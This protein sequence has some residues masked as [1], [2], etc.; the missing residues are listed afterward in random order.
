LAADDETPPTNWVLGSSYFDCGSGLKS[1]FA[2][3]GALSTSASF[4]DQG[5]ALTPKGNAMKMNSKTFMLAV[6]FSFAV[7]GAWIGGA[8]AGDTKGTTTAPPPPPTGNKATTKKS[9]NSGASTTGYTTANPVTPGGYASGGWQ[10]GIH[11]SNGNQ[12]KQ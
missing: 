7:S 9:Y 3:D 6:I 11:Q 10:T 12:N 5:L 1:N 8:Q 4:L 2:I